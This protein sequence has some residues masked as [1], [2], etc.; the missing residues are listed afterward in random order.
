M[1]VDTVSKRGGREPAHSPLLRCREKSMCEARVYCCMRGGRPLRGCAA[2][3]LND[4]RI[5]LLSR[6]YIH[7]P[8]LIS[9]VHICLV[10]GPSPQELSHAAAI[11]ASPSR[12]RMNASRLCLRH[13]CSSGGPL[14]T[15]TR[16]DARPRQQLLFRDFSAWK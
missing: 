15:S 3:P 5:F 7:L 10:R 13:V 4:E 11:L 14:G 16:F 2:L 1:G 8:P 6:L 9:I 12:Y